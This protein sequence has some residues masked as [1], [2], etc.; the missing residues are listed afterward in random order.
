[1][2]KLNEDCLFEAKDGKYVEVSYSNCKAI[3]A[4]ELGNAIWV[5]KGV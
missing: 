5:S 3:D 1:M 2:E 4:K